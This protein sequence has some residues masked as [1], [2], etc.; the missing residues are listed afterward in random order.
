M[1]PSYSKSLLVYVFSRI[2]KISSLECV[3]RI[4]PCSGCGSYVL[5]IDVPT[6]RLESARPLWQVRVPAVAAAANTSSSSSSSSNAVDT[7]LPAPE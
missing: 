6:H 4:S 1:K 2:G 7:Y 3:V 5:V